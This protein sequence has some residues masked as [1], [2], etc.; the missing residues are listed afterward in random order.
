MERIYLD[1]A[2]TSPMHPMVIEKMLEVMQS[3]FGNP[4]SIHSYGREARHLIDQAR[5][6][7]AGSIGAKETKELAVMVDTFHPLMLT[8]EALDI[9]N[10]NYVMSWAE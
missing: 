5:S 10:E 9:E 2:A 7:L 8:K 1:H 6:V 4:S 3:T